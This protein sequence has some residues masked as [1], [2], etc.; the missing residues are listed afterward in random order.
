MKLFRPTLH[1]TDR[2]RFTDLLGELQKAANDVNLS[3]LAAL[4]ELSQRTSSAHVD[5]FKDDLQCTMLP[6]TLATELF[7]IMSVSDTMPVRRLGQWK[8]EKESENESERE[9]VCVSVCE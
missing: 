2:F 1:S 5:V 4:L 7:R 8:K 3:R 6:F 9:P